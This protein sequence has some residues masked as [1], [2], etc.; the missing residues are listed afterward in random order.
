M[1]T[2]C[3]ECNT[4]I[5]YQCVNCDDLKRYRQLQVCKRHVLKCENVKKYYCPHCGYVALNKNYIEHHILENHQQVKPKRSK[6]SS[7]ISGI[8]FFLIF[9]SKIF[10]Y[11]IKLFIIKL[12]FSFLQFKIK[13]LKRKKI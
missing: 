5:L 12:Q 3:A 10:L 11:S 1:S 7:K 9:V 13:V 6:N 2:A 4:P 8:Y